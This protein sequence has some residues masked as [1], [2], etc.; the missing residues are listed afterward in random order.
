MTHP[1]TVEAPTEGVADFS[2]V[3][4]RV[5]VFD[6]FFPTTQLVQLEKWALQTPHW[7]LNNSAHDEHGHAQHRIWGASYIQALQRKGWSGLPPV[8]LA[9]VARVFQKLGV[10]IPK[11]EYIGLNGQSRGQNGSAHTDCV[12]DAADQ[13]S[14]LIYVGED[15]DGDLLLYSKDD[16]GQLTERIGFRPNRVVAF[17]GSIP[18]AALAPSDD[19]FRMSVIVRGAYECRQPTAGPS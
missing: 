3:L 17:D 6:D 2:R 5:F 9:A 7:M 4:D 12:R 19:K 18:H 14:I 10:K 16:P 13:L 1:L 15:T 11:P 8:L